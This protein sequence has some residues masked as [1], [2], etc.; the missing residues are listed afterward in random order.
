[1]EECFRTMKTDFEARPVYL[2]R[3]HRIKAHFLIF[4]YC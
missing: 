1:M 4:W 2:Q 3:V